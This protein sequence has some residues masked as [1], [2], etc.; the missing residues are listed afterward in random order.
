MSEPTVLIKDQGPVRVFTLNRP[1]QLN[2]LNHQLGKELMDGLAEAENDAQVRAVVLTGAGRA[3]SAGAD[4]SRFAAMAAQDNSA[5]R[6]S[7]TGLGFPRAM[8][9][10]PKPI[11]AAVNGPAVGWGLTVSLMCDLRVM[12][13]DAYFSAGFVRVGVTPE[14]GSSFLLPAIVGLGRALDMTLTARKVPADEALAMGLA[15]RVAPG[16]GLMDTAME[17]ADQVAAHPAPA[18]EMAKTLIHHGAGAA[19]EQVLDYEIRCFR[20]AMATPEHKAAVEAMLE[21]IKARRKG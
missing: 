20:S 11:I 18:V 21:A 19:L 2:A 14:F 13:S 4:L 10:F 7:F 1:E 8:A 17:L 6:E 9:N 16:E 12:A 5:A 3:F 15:N